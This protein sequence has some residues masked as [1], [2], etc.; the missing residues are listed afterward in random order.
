MF[1]IFTY[2][3]EFGN[4]IYEIYDWLKSLDEKPQIICFQEFPEK[5]INNLGKNKIFKKQVF[6]FAPGVSNKK[7]IFGELT[8]FDLS[9]INKIEDKYLDFGIDKIESIYKR[10]YIE[11]SALLTSFK[12]SN[13]IISVANIHLT[14]VSLHGKRK[15]Q[16]LKVIQNTQNK[17]SII[18]GDFNYSSLL[19]RRGL[20]SFME[21]H[22]YDL[23]GEKS[24]T[25]KYKNKIPQQLD[26]VFYK[27]LT[28][29][30]AT[31]IPLPYS[32]HYPV[33]ATFEI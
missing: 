7:H 3:V 10:K 14:P 21:S 2:N 1:S 30:K 11:R 28:S 8:I 15:K 29:I 26:Y 19:G 23:A 27:G 24:V 17:K 12:I 6:S 25:N 20:I 5:E 13:K 18:L 33:S 31:V 4:K 22:G 32:D 16:L 9:K